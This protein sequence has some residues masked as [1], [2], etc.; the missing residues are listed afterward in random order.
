M[1]SYTAIGYGTQRI[2]TVLAKDDTDARQKIAYELQKN[3]SR[4][5]YYELWVKYGKQIVRNIK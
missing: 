5:F 4:T 3:P 2:I 1:D